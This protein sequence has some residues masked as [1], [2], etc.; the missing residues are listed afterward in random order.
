M[1]ADA[2]DLELEFGRLHL[3]DADLPPGVSSD[4]HLANSVLGGPANA[5]TDTATDEARRT[6]CSTSCDVIRET[7]FA[8]YMLI[9]H[10]FAQFARSNGIAMGVRGSAAA[11]LVLYCL[12][13]T[14]IDPLAHGLVFERFLNIERREMP[15]VDFDFADDRRD[16][17]DP[18]RRA[19][20]RRRSRRADHHLRHARREGAIRDIG[21]ALGMTYADTDRVARLIPPLLHMTIDRAL[22]DNAE[23]RAVYEA[24]EQVR[25]LVDTAQRLEGV[26]RHASTHAAGVVISQRAARRAR[27]APAPA[28]R[29]DESRRCRRRSTRWSRWRRSAC[30]RWT[31]WASS[32]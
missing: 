15:D 2:C 29:G 27:A 20:V 5:A 12:G 25:K 21:R 4:E 31:S 14:D 18:L 23:L 30:S 19:K 26:A 32:T 3:P 10:D 9:V 17:S 16:E 6:A 24:D 13:V 22:E 28:A 11:S 1:I 7:G 8:N